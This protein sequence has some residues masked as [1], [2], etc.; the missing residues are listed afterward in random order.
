[1]EKID[2]QL[3]GRLREVLAGNKPWPLVLW[4][5]TGT[6]KS[7]VALC[8]CDHCPGSWFVTSET[9]GTEWA[10]VLCGRLKIG[11]GR[12]WPSNYRK[13]IGRVRLM[14]VDDAGSR[15]KVSDTA[16]EAF[17]MVLDLREGK[18]LIVTSNHSPAVLKDIYDAR[19]ADRLMAG[20]VIELTGKSR[21]RA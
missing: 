16:Y 9:L 8:L 5:S 4:G 2:R 21:R 11:D 13:R 12:I 17:K 19:I 14:V 6:G 18:P 7:C 10:D 15:D 3:R 1:M 20:T